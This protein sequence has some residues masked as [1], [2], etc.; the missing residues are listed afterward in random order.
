MG[1]I[2]DMWFTWIIDIGGPGPD[3][4]EGGRYLIVP[5][6]YDGPLPEG[7]FF[8]GHS[9]TDHV[10]YAA[11]AY[12]KYNDPKPAVDNIKANLKIYPYTPGGVG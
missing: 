12:L 6:G 1:T 9:K 2:N 11:R 4:G 7:G 8:I 5:P 10:L 3:R